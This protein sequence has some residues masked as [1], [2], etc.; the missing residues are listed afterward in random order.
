M[1][2]NDPER[3]P[4]RCGDLAFALLSLGRIDEAK[5]LFEQAYASAQ[6]LGSR[7]MIAEGMFNLGKVAELR[8]RHEEARAWRERAQ[9]EF[10]RLGIVRKG[11]VDQFCR[12]VAADASISS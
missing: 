6:K 12:R 8:Q 11:R 1:V 5:G 3:Y 4:A 7:V 2:E 10:G 9:H